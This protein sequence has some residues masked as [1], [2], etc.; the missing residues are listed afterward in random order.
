MAQHFGPVVNAIQW[1]VPDL[2]R[3]DWRVWP[4]YQ[5]A[6]AESTMLWSI[7]MALAYIGLMLALAVAS[8]RRREL[9]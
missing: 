4:M 2:S 8:C 3:L 7:I 1:L 6:P 9:I 5:L